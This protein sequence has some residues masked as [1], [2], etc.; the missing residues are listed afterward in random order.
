MSVVVDVRL[1][2]I[3]RRMESHTYTKRIFL[4]DCYSSH[5]VII[6][7]KLV[8]NELLDFLVFG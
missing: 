8:L 4:L 5:A 3:G 6:I 7:L 1:H 2:I